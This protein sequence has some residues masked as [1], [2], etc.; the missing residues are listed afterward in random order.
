M[1]GGGSP[2]PAPTPAPAPPPPVDGPSAPEL[3]DKTSDRNN[4]RALRRGRGSLRINLAQAGTGET[5][6]TPS[7]LNIP[8]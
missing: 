5:S 4:Q 1:C 8:T 3:N 6:S 2:K 7:G